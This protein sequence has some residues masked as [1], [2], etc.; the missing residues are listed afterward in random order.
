M[1]LPLRP[2]SRRWLALAA[3]PFTLVCCAS[4]GSAPATGTAA[5][6]PPAREARESPAFVG[7]P[8]VLDRDD[9]SLG[10]TV[11]FGRIPSPAE[12]N[13]LP[14]TSGA[15][16]VV[17]SLPAWPADFAA[18]ETLNRRPV[19][20]DVLVV[21]P[22]WP[23]TRGAAEA[24]NMVRAPLRLVVLATGAPP[25]R[26]MLDDLNAMRALERVIVQTDRPSRV[27]LERLQRPLSFRRIV[28]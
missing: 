24:W 22:G 12:F 26:G 20:L 17:I 16:R 27:G 19:D 2:H 6:P 18:I 8:L 21:L 5:S 15:S 3:L 14:Y 7:V 25:T 4:G 11:Q 28:P 10:T 1:P 23:P 9:L 13:D